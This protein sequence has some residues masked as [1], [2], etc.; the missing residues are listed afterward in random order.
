MLEYYSY[1]LAIRNNVTNFSALHFST[2]LF[3]QYIVDAYVKIESNR[4]NFIKMNQSLLH[5]EQYKGLMDH[6]KNQTGEAI[7]RITILPSSFQVNFKLL[8]LI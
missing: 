2:K 1:R 7:G 4:L 5:V 3:H 6:I 8:K